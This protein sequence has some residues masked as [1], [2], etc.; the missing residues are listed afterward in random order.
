VDNS[1]YRWQPD[2]LFKGGTVPAW[3]IRSNS[4]TRDPTIFRSGREGDFE[5]HIPLAPGAW[6]LHLYFAN[7][8]RGADGRARIEHEADSAIDIRVNGRRLVHQLDVVD[9]AGAPTAA[10]ERV[11]SD[12]QPATDGVLHLAFT[13]LRGTACLSGIE[14]L[15]MASGQPRPV[16]IVAGLKPY[17]DRQGH[18]WEPDHFLSGGIL[19]ARTNAIRGTGDPALY[20]GE[21]YGEFSCAIPLAAGNYRVRAHFAETWFGPSNP[22]K[23]GA[24]S[25]SAYEHALKCAANAG[26]ACELAFEEAKDSQSNQSDRRRGRQCCPR[27]SEDD[28]RAQRY[29]SSNDIRTSDCEGTGPCSLWVGRLKT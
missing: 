8:S 5:Y 9:A 16:R 24:G 11:F 20:Q 23:G 7:A 17:T 28:I 12:I 3:P 27:V 26:R 13:G 18:R 1:G 19:V 25:E 2:R 6:E 21:R 4:G 22:G 10:L 29:E 14:L 15:R